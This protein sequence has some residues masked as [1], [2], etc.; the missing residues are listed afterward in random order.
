MF[1]LQISEWHA[2]LSVPRC[3][4]KTTWHP[5]IF[6]GWISP[7]FGGKPLALDNLI[8]VLI[9]VMLYPK[10]LY[11]S[12]PK[13]KLKMVGLTTPVFLAYPWLVVE[14]TTLKNVLRSLGMI[15]RLKH[16]EIISCPIWE[17][18]YY[19]HIITHLITS[20]YILYNILWLV[21][22]YTFSIQSLAEIC[23]MSIH[24]SSPG[25]PHRQPSVRRAAKLNQSTENINWH[26]MLPWRGNPRGK[27]L[28][29]QVD[30]I[31][32]P[33]P[34]NFPQ[35]RLWFLHLAWLGII[36]IPS[37][38]KVRCRLLHWFYHVFFV[39]KKDNTL[40]IWPGLRILKLIFND[41]LTICIWTSSTSCQLSL[42]MN[43]L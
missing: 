37:T 33:G 19:T 43:S 16:V 36:E 23:A 25:G 39:Q 31:G 18:L 4:K 2:F 15:V 21:C 1:H 29:G 10:V 24:L 27:R 35:P 7:P 38:K 32:Y 14:K 17:G 6:F 40:P 41:L 5:N 42:L 34:Q 28:L 9:H 8:I 22:P 11:S 12:P 13:K 20:I 26:T 3:E 30:T